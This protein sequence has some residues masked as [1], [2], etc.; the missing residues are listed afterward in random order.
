[1]CAADP[2][3]MGKKNKK[4]EKPAQDLSPSDYHR[5][6][7]AQ[8]WWETAGAKSSPKQQEAECWS[9]PLRPSWDPRGQR[10]QLACPTT[11]T[12]RRWCCQAQGPCAEPYVCANTSFTAG[13][14]LGLGLGLRARHRLQRSRPVQKK[15]FYLCCVFFSFFCKLIFKVSIQNGGS[16]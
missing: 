14:G 6:F 12:L 5:G 3:R 11:H 7:G 1:M 15:V 9:T 10:L 2:S 8:V 13:Q 16:R 4:G